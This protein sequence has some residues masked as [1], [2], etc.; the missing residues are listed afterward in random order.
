M[1]HCCTLCFFL[2]RPNLTFINTTTKM[3]WRLLLGHYFLAPFTAALSVPCLKCRSLGSLD[4]YCSTCGWVMTVCR[5][6]K[7]MVTATVLQLRNDAFRS[8]TNDWLV[9]AWKQ[10]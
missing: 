9:L 8:G 10:S 1:A 3:P 7:R 5:N 6:Q 4:F 2:D